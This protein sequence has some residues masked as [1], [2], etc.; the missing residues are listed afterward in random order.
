MPTV[1]LNTGI[2]LYYESHGAGEPL[3]FIPATGMAGNVWDKTQVPALS[4]HLRVV[5]HDPRGTGRTSKPAGVYS[6]D[7]MACDVAA[8]MDHLGIASAHIIGHSMGGRIGLALTLAFPGRV[9][10]LILAASGSGPASRSGEDC[11]VGLPFNLVYSLVEKGFD[12]HVRHEVCESTGFFTTEF[13]KQ[14]PARV[15]EFFEQAWPLHARW[16]EYL[17]LCL[18][19]QMW[20]ATHRLGDIKAP[21]L[22]AIGDADTVGSNHLTQA[23]VMAERIP[24]A[25]YLVLKGQSHGFFWQAPEETNA[26]ILDWVKRHAG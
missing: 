19:R 1:R 8:L 3:F 16:P 18:A 24:K 17:R 21:T 11:V 22:V 2:E 4:K 25:E 7:Q 15:R 23:E 9:K 6:L 13:L 26:W 14:Q 20:E 5:T 10:S 12:G